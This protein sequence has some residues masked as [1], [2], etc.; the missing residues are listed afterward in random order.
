V[1]TACTHKHKHRSASNDK[2]WRRER[3]QR[4][5]GPYEVFQA[6]IARTDDN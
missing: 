4:G 3:D 6:F 2:A 1:R 5:S